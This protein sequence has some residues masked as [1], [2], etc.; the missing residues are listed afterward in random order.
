[1]ELIQAITRILFSFEFLARKGLVVLATH[2]VHFLEQ[3]DAI[4]VLKCWQ[5]LI[6]TIHCLVQEK[7]QIQ[8]KFIESLTK[9]SI[10]SSEILDFGYS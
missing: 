6:R 10:S 2:T 4:G 9:I 5:N 7:K 8:S 1:M 3:A